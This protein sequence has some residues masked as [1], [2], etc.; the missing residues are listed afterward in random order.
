MTS[1]GKKRKA[2]VTVVGSLATQMFVEISENFM[3][4]YRVIA[5]EDGYTQPEFA[6]LV[7]SGYASL[8]VIFVDKIVLD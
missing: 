1:E 6:I 5:F 2:I 8:A 4:T 7:P 3:I